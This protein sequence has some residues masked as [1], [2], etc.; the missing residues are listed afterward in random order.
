MEDDYV[1]GWTRRIILPSVS[2]DR[3]PDKKG[4][5]EEDDTE[6]YKADLSRRAG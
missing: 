3:D 4:K 5:P 2:I 1:T 6:A